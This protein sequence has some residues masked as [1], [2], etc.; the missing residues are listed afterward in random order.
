MAQFCRGQRRQITCSRILTPALSLV[1]LSGICAKSTT[2]A[3]IT[4]LLFT[5]PCKTLTECGEC[6]GNSQNLYERPVLIV[7]PD[8]PT[9]VV[10]AAAAAAA[11]RFLVMGSNDKTVRI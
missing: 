10:H 8:V 11:G 3:G 7:D 2:T 4:N 9:A 6:I 1:I 5:Q